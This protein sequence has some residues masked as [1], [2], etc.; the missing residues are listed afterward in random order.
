MKK[1]WYIFINSSHIGPYSLIE[2]KGFYEKRDIKEN[3]LVWKE[4]MT[5][6]LPLN[7][8]ESFSVPISVSIEDVPPPLPPDVFRK[9]SI[10]LILK[11]SEIDLE[12]STESQSEISDKIKKKPRY[13]IKIISFI[14]S[15]VLCFAGFIVYQNSISPDFRIKG[16]SPY[17][18]EQLQKQLSIDQKN[19]GLAIV[20]TMDKSNLWVATNQNSNLNVTIDLKAEPGRLLR[21]DQEKNE[22]IEVRLQGKIANHLGHFTSMKMLKGTKFFPGE[23]NVHVVGKKIH[24]LNQYLKLNLDVLNV[25]FTVDYKNLIFSG[26]TREFER[27][28][29][30]INIAKKILKIRPL[31]DKLETLQTL[32]SLNEKNRE[33]FKKNL[34]VSTTGKKFAAFEQDYLKEVSPI[35]QVLVLEAVKDL[36]KNPANKR[37]DEGIIDFGKKIGE[38]ASQMITEITPMKKINKKTSSSLNEKFTSKSDAINTMISVYIGELEI[39]IKEIP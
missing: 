17:N 12:Q 36:E 35:V 16:I 2:I 34:E 28:L 15:L 7:K 23:Y 6:W 4:G 9:T 11:D 37:L 25:D 26:N 30:E 5:E 13:L 22:E 31:Q 20:L 1:E 19:I 18:R 14:L 29:I 24:W 38:L 8:V 39:Q 10:P 33:L 27:K 21:D 32:K 3:T